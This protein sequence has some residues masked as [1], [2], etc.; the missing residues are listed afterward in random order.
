MD[1]V[2]LLLLVG[3]FG[4]LSLLLGGFLIELRGAR[5]VIPAMQRGAE[6][7]VLTG[8]L[9][10]GAR[11]WEHLAVDGP[12]TGVKLVIALAVLALTIVGKRRP[13]QTAFY[14]GAGLLTIANVA[15]AVFWQ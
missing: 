11:E 3:H 1:V 5:R 4:G 14:L 10:V 2:R 9:L 8:I 13:T 7:Q 15:V 6:I 12:K